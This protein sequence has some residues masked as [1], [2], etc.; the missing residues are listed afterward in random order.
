MTSLQ[1]VVIFMLPYLFYLFFVYR[2]PTEREP[3]DGEPA[4][5]AG[6]SLAT[7][8]EEDDEDLFDI[9]SLRLQLNADDGPIPMEY[10]LSSPVK[11]TQPMSG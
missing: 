3:A 4:D 10:L 7:I 9:S 2:A 1:R 8:S 5:G 6:D 11:E